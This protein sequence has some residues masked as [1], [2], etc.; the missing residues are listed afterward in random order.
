MRGTPA[1]QVGGLGAP[2]LQQSGSAL[3][4]FLVYVYSRAISY[5]KDRALDMSFQTSALR[6]GWDRALWFVLLLIPSP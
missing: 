1:A 6:D 3:V 2:L 5:I 4:F